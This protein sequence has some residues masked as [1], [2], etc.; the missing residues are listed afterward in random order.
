MSNH[1]SKRAI[2]LHHDQVNAGR[3]RRQQR[4]DER[5]QNYL[6]GW[7]EARREYWCIITFGVLCFSYAMIAT[8]VY[9]GYIL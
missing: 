1:H 4:Q 8:A 3:V 5:M 7:Q 6:I 2:N 9:L